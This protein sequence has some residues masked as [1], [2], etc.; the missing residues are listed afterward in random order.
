MNSSVT[1]TAN[2]DMLLYDTQAIST[3]NQK[4]QLIHIGSGGSADPSPVPHRMLLCGRVVMVT[5]GGIA[6]T[7]SS[8]SND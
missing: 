6:L 4:F 3:S 2:F 8:Y 5:A 7:L 1:F